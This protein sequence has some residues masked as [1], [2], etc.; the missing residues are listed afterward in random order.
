MAK[1]H[2]FLEM[3]QG[4]QNLHVAQQEFHAQNKKMTAIGYIS[5]TDV[6]LRVS[7][8]FLQYDGAAAFKLSYRTPLP[9]A[10]STKDLHGGQTHTINVRRIR[11][12][13]HPPVER[14]EDIA[15]RSIADTLIWPNLNGLFDNPTESEDDYAVH[16]ES[17]IEQHDVIKDLECPM[18]QNVSATPSVPRLVQPTLKSKTQ[19]ELELVMVNAI[20]T[21]TNTAVKNM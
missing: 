8:S 20:E 13:N 5:D 18:Q 9:P 3:W 6:S 11:R 12:I 2:D 1:V 16:N 10:L 7:W 4:T 17:H 21:R 19:V 15:H 14:N